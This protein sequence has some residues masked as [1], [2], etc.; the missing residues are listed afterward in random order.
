MKI[1]LLENERLVLTQALSTWIY[2]LNKNL[3][4]G[5][6]ANYHDKYLIEVQNMIVE[7]RAV[8]K[9]VQI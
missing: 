2:Q 8:R 3:S 6:K 9:K 4:K 7:A 5:L 1:D